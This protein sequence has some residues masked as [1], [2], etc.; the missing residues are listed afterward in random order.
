MV[1]TILSLVFVASLW[2]HAEAT[3]LC[4]RK[5]AAG[6]PRG[7]VTLREACK[8]KEVQLDP[9]TLGVQG[10]AV[11]DAT[12]KKVGD[13]TTVNRGSAV[14]LFRLNQY[15][16]QLVVIPDGH[17]YAISGAESRSLY[18][19]S[20]DCTGT[21]LVRAQNPNTFAPSSSIGPPGQTLYL[22]DPQIIPQLI[23]VYSFIEHDPPCV[24]IPS[25]ENY[26]YYHV[27]AIALGDLSQLFTP[28]FSV[29]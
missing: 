5:D 19:E 9:V 24:A 10:P 2:S 6:N 22:A 17:F 4:A 29:R 14:I 11:Y 18:F 13:P 28:P 26:Y 23:R 16:L 15:S 12:G 7:N 3:V 27:P 20:T 21:P 8:S 1:R 25:H